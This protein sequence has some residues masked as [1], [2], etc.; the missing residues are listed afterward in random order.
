MTEK[1]LIRE[2]IEYNKK[3]RNAIVNVIDDYDPCDFEDFMEYTEAMIDYTLGRLGFDPYD[4][5]NEED[6]NHLSEIL[7][8][9]YGDFLI[10]TYENSCE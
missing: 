10:S 9:N 7:L 8:N 5:E 3:V 4:E 2:A 6:Y 1:K